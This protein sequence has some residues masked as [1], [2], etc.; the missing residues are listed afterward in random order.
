MAAFGIE[1]MWKDACIHIPPQK[2][3]AKDFEVEAD[4]SA[5]SYFYSM[6]A[7][8]DDCEL[9]LHGLFENSLQGDAVLTTLMKNFGVST[10]FNPNSIVIK[11]SGSSADTVFEWDFLPCPDLAQTIAVVCGG[12]GI[13]GLFSGLHTL[14]I[15][16]TDRIQALKNELS[17]IKVLFSEVPAR[18]TKN[19]K[20]EL[21]LLDG[22]AS[23]TEPVVFSTYEDHRMAMAFAP[24]ALLHEIEIEEPGVVN[25]SYP[26][27]WKDLNKLGFEVKE[28]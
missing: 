24:L 18:L 20:S 13:Q 28:T 5:A 21:F 7:L 14:R 3:Q 9:S 12:L 15:K 6:A 1:H 25:K 8:S 16:E 2:Y 10:D 23:F 22:R 26:A 27:F 11:K 19:V 4:W 17:K